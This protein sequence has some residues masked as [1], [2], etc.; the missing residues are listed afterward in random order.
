MQF[1]AK[2]QKLRRIVI[3]PNIFNTMN[4]TEKGYVLVEVNPIANEEKND[5][6]K[7]Q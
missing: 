5:E 3:P 7:I 4:L 1:V 2:I 6:I